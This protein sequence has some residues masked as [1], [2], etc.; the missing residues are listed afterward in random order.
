MREKKLSLRIQIGSVMMFLCLVYT[1]IQS[2]ATVTP[3][4]IRNNG[5]END[6]HQS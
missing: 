2:H 3:S 6:N 4:L 5:M 1:T